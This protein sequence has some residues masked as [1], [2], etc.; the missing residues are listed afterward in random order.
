MYNKMTDSIVLYLGN[1]L[2][3]DTNDVSFNDATVTINN[4]PTTDLQIAN[5]IYVDKTDAQL[6]SANHR[7]IIVP[8]TA[9]VM[10]LQAYPTVMTTTIQNLSYDG[11]YYKKTSNAGA[12][13]KINWYVG[14]D[15][16]MTVA[17]IEQI[18]FEMYLIKYN[19]SK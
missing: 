19:F 11:W 6:K 10:G 16:N 12:N 17:D 18:F 9:A 15:A 4:E 3:L 2:R 8:L 13:T 5:K 7:T 1:K 14:P